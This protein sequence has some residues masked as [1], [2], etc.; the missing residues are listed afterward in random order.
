M[1][2]LKMKAHGTNKKSL[3]ELIVDAI[4]DHGI[5]KVLETMSKFIPKEMDVTQT[6][7]TPE[8]WLEMMADAGQSESAES[9]DSISGP[10][11]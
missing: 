3:S 1:R 7:L 6:E 5:L 10:V 2:A 11:H 8:K 4:D 9:K